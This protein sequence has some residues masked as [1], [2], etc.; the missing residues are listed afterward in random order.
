MQRIRV[1]FSRGEEVKYLSHL[2]LMRLWERALRRADIPLAYS[3]GFS[4][5]PRISIAAPLPIGVTSSSELMDIL[6][7]KRFSPY[8]FIKAVGE[9]LPNGIGLIGVEQVA[10]QLPS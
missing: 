7:N 10:M 4:P 5:H 3:Q 1:T 2:D 6:F 9:Q 8:Y